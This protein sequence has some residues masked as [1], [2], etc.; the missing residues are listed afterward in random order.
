MFYEV[1]NI[2]IISNELDLISKFYLHWYVC[3]GYDK[4][5]GTPM[6]PF[7]NETFKHASNRLTKYK[8]KK[9]VLKGG[10]KS[11][12]KRKKETEELLAQL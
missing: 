2:S 7:Q 8:P 12:A 9:R 4:A 11:F 6:N 1:C 3:R 10:A 5:D